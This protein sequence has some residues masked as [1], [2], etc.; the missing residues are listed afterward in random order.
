MKLQDQEHLN[1]INAYIKLK[2]I[3]EGYEKNKKDKKD[4]EN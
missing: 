4:N 3:N 2:K 1:K